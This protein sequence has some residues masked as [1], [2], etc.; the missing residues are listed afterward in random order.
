MGEASASSA[1]TLGFQ[2]SGDLTVNKPNWVMW[3]VIGVVAIL[4]VTLYLRKK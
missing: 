4:A 1:A 2:T 3:V